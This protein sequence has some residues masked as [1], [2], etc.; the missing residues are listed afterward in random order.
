MTSSR[1]KIL[2]TIKYNQPEFIKLTLE[3][4]F[5]P[6]FDDIVE[7]FK[8]V[9]RGIGGYLYEV[10][11]NDDLLTS[12]ESNFAEA[13]RIISCIPGVPGTEKNEI[14]EKDSHDYDDV[15]LLIISSRMAVAENG[16][17]WVT[18]NEIQVR[19]LPFITEHLLVVVNTK[20][21]VATMHDAYN[22]IAAEQYGFATFIAGPSRTADIEQSLVLGAHG[23]RIMTVFLMN[24]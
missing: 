16:A 21:I 3:K 4:N 19:V 15:D 13:R 22:L 20:N 7:K 24:A 11:S 6:P 23:A 17:V 1:E 9:F 18:D 14:N 5:V 12:I 8:E 10:S 2:K